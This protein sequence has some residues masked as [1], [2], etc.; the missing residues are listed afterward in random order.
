MCKRLGYL[1]LLFSVSLLSCLSDK[2][3]KSSRGIYANYSISGE[4]GKEFVTVF[5]QFSH[6]P[7]D[8][9]SVLADPAKVF[10]DD[11]LL[12]ADSAQESGA[13][14]EVQIPVKDFAGRHV[15]RYID[16]AQ[17][18]HREEFSFIPFQV[19]GQ[20]DEAVSRKDL[21]LQL[22]GV[23]NGDLLRVV[24]IDTAIGGEGVNE[25][26]TIQ[27]N[28]LDLKRFLPAVANG[29][30]VLEL[31]KEEDRNLSKGQNGK[32]S[33]TYGLKREFELKD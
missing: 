32:I 10:L 21:V 17:K 23:K 1:F 4:E 27:N 30:L 6:G 19:A 11:F 7:E 12:T 3:E 22:Q 13:F 14:Y 2:Q 25:V 8:F 20:L 26:D 15:I 5:L 29:P 33:I 31:F 18:E 9:A 24:M 16:E 28:Q